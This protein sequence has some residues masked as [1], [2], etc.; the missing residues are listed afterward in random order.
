[1]AEGRELRVEHATVSF[2]ISRNAGLLAL[3]D[4]TLRIPPSQIVSLVGPSGCGKTTVLRLVAGFMRPTHGRVVLGGV[5]IT[6]P[7]PD[8]GVVFQQPTLFPWLNVLD[9]VI[10]APKLRGIPV[11]TYSAEAARYL[12]AVGLAG[13]ERQYPYQLSGGMKQRLQIARVLINAPELLLMDEPFGALD[14]QTRLV[15]QELVLKLWGAYQ[16]SVLF[17]THDVDEAIFL[18]DTVYVMA[19]QPGRVLEIIKIP[20]DR[21]RSYHELSSS[22]EFITLRLNILAL[23]GHQRQIQRATVAQDCP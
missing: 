2:P 17:I 1:M 15:M 22:H 4:V 14:Y 21:P 10:L 11:S 9:N 20:F 7:G 19:S 13:H 12:E 3:D 18:S 6:A 5:D 23:L 16:P 8:R